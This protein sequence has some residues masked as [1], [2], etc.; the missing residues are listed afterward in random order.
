[1]PMPDP[2]AAHQDGLHT[3]YHDLQPL[4][5]DLGQAAATPVQQLQHVSAVWQP[6]ETGTS[7]CGAA[8]Q[9]CFQGF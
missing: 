2:A 4:T 5:Q 3:W 8:Y 1:M 6:V 9:Y 7:T